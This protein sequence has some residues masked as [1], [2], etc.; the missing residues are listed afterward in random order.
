[1]TD[2]SKT[3]ISFYGT[4]TA[5]AT[6]ELK[7]ILAI[8]NENNGLMDD[9]AFMAL[10]QESDSVAPE[11]IQSVCSKISKQILRADTVLKNL[12]QFAHLADKN[13]TSIDLY[14]NISY[15]LIFAGRLIERHEVA[16]NIEPPEEPHLF[17]M[18]RFQL[19]HVIW[20][21]LETSCRCI[22]GDKK[23]D[24]HIKSGSKGQTV[25]FKIFSPTDFWLNEFKI[26][27]ET[28]STMSSV[29]LILYEDTCSFEL[30]FSNC[31]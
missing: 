21:T 20:L 26:L 9:L 29:E 22:L 18:D 19:C 2:D 1:M 30:D 15:M 13:K 27:Q 31:S 23:I 14:D 10:N 12:N 25:V 7:N 6:H 24:V 17:L 3:P 28:I 5:S 16:V 11:R 8:I 4:M